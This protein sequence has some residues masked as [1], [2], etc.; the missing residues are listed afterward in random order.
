MHIA[1]AGA[2]TY[3]AHP[4]M[5]STAYDQDGRWPIETFPGFVTCANLNPQWASFIYQFLHCEKGL[6]PWYSSRPFSWQDLLAC[7]PWPLTHFFPRE[8]IWL[9]SLTGQS[10]SKDLPLR[11]GTAPGSEQQVGSTES[12]HACLCDMACEQGQAPLCWRGYGKSR[13]GAGNQTKVHGGQR[14]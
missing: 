5:A 6:L 11:W 12:H 1:L 14:H 10:A 4:D 3:F 7:S 2:L 9:T 8:G 13:W